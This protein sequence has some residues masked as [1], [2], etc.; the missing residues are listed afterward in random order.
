M[1][2]LT[3][4]YYLSYLTIFLTSLKAH[5]FYIFVELLIL[6]MLRVNFILDVRHYVDDRHYIINICCN[7]VM[8]IMLN[9]L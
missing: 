2:A 8:A 4:D 5:C 9:L 6:L 1:D 3:N 7:I